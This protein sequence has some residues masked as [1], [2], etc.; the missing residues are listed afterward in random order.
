MKWSNEAEK[1]LNQLVEPAKSLVKERAE[2][3]AETRHVDSK[4][5]M[6][7]LVTKAVFNYSLMRIEEEGEIE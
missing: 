7:P 6:P 3:V 5:N 2:K 1:R 4:S